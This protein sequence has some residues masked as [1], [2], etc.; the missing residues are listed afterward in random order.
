MRKASLLL[1]IFILML[2]SCIMEKKANALFLVG[3]GVPIFAFN[4]ISYCMSQEGFTGKE[5][6]WKDSKSLIRECISWLE[7][8][9]PEYLDGTLSDWID[10]ANSCHP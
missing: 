5:K 2:C 10:Y 7:V 9:Q 1:A 3:E 6:S 8:C 4:D